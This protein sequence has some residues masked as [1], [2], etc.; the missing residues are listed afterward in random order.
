M[1]EIDGRHAL[2]FG[3]RKYISILITLT[4]AIILGLVVGIVS[5]VSSLHMELVQF[6]ILL[7]CMFIAFYINIYKENILLPYVILIWALSPEIRRVVDWLFHTYSEVSIISVI[8]YCVSLI[9][10]VPILRNKSLL[11]RRIKFIAIIMGVTLTYGFCIGFLKYGMASVFDFLNYAVPFLVLI[12]VNVCGLNIDVRNRWLKNFSYLGVF[13]AAYGIYQY[14]VLPQ[15]DEF[16]MINADMNSIGTPEP[17]NFRLFS[18]INSPGPTGLFLAFSLAIM[19]VQKKWRAFGLVGMMIVAFA[20]LLTLVRSGWIAFI[21]LILA[22]L[23]RSQLKNK[24]MLIALLA[25]IGLAY[26]FILPMLPGASSITSRIETLNSLEGDHS[27]NERLSFSTNILSDIIRNPI[28]K[29]L[30]STGLGTKISN[31]SS[32]FVTFDNGYLN[33]FYTFGLPLGLAL[34]ATLFYLAIYF[35]K[36]S[37]KEK[38]FFPI[39]F[40][41]IVASLFLLSGSNIIQGISGVIVWF[42]AAL[43]FISPPQHEQ[44]KGGYLP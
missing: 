6:T 4:V 35:Y 10:L 13:V 26:Q 8:P 5:T 20:L 28:G 24:I 23:I 27:F 1:E 15:W 43:A 18:T 9:L 34:I 40:A 22:Y 29:G 11:N 39:S 17:L 25:V 32:D 41:A 7:N 37:G 33:I 14:L 12:Y 36:S 2:K 21:V 16:W 38:V 42:I 30:G 31:N 3:V 44:N 19:I